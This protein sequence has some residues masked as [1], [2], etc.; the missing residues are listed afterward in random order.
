V[1]DLLSLWIGH[2]DKRLGPAEARERAAAYMQKM[3]DWSGN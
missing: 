2:W 3:P 1:E